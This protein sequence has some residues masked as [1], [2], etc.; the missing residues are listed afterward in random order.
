MSVYPLFAAVEDLL[1]AIIKPL[2]EDVPGLKVR[3]LIEDDTFTTPYVFVHAGTGAYTADTFGG[4]NISDG[5][6][7]RKF[8]ADVQVW[9]DGPDSEAKAWAIHELIRDKLSKAYW[10][11]IVYPG[12]GHLCYFRTSSPAHKTPDW[13]T[14]TGVNQYANL[15]KGMVRYQATYGMAM[16]PPFDSKITAADLVAFIRS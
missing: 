5:R 2:E 1:L 13:A 11:Q 8:I 7:Q 10:E 9:T 15:P 4:L 3:T 12:I 14:A 16:R 6:F